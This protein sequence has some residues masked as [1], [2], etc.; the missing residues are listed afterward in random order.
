[1]S[2]VVKKSHKKVRTGLVVKNKM[3]KSIIV[4][5]ERR[6]GHALYKKVVK[7]HKKYAVHDEDNVCN[8]GDFVEIIETRPISKTVRWK[9]SKI[10][11]KV[12]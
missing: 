9:L 5:V 6:D 12:K 10:I 4:S 8:V 11:T 7:I 2:E 3:E 1:M